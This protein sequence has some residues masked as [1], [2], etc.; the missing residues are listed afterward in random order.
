MVSVEALPEMCSLWFV[1]ITVLFRVYWITLVDPF[2]VIVGIW[3]LFG[4]IK[5]L[6]YTDYMFVVFRN[7]DCLCRIQ[8]WIQEDMPY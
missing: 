3:Q 7:Y 4:T 2:G 6:W 1:W 5:C 8:G